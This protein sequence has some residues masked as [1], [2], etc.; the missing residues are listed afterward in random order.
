MT[1]QSIERGFAVLELLDRAEKSQ[2]I[3]EM[4]RQLDL[5][6]SNVQRLINTLVALGYVVPDED[7]KRYKLSYKSLFL[8]HSLLRQDQLIGAATNELNKMAAEQ[9]VGAYLAVL[10]EDRAVYLMAVQGRGTISVGVTPGDSADLHSSAMGKALLLGKSEGDIRSI[11]GTSGMEE[12]TRHTITNVDD[13]L[14]DVA[15]ASER[16]YT[17][18]MEENFY[19]VVSVGAPIFD[20]SGDVAAS[21]SV[22]TPYSPDL[23]ELVGR[24]SAAVMA[25]TQKVSFNLGHK[26]II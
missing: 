19:G 6:P 17:L 16:G 7:T 4:G 9:E 13:L 8:G 23:D 12:R 2:G 26:A 18:S 10:R 15:I 3:R 20:H 14:R 22:S 24:L 1:N 21:I 25:C 11:M 5:H